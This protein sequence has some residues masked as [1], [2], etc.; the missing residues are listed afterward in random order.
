VFF[1]VRRFAQISGSAIPFGARG[2]AAV[3]FSGRPADLQAYS[4]LPAETGAPPAARR[5]RRR[6][7]ARLI[8]GKEP[9]GV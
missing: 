5:R 4:A 2:V 7:V 3:I 8:I 6:A 1:P 9:V